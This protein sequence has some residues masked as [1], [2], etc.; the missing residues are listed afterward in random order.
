MGAPKVERGALFVRVGISIVDAR[1]AADD[2]GFVIERYWGRALRSIGPQL[3]AL[4]KQIGIF[5]LIADYAR[6]LW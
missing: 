6:R 5:G 1:Y 4:A 2:A 3:W